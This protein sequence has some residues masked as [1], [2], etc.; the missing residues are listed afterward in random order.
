ME[1]DKMIEFLVAYQ[2]FARGVTIHGTER[3]IHNMYR[4]SA[5][6]GLCAALANFVDI[7]VGGGDG[8]MALYGRMM[9]QLQSAIANL[10][11]DMNPTYPFGGESI[12]AAH[13]R[14]RTQHE[15][16]LRLKFVDDFLSELYNTNIREN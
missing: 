6:T 12:Y 1:D 7:E 3:G 15:N 10:A 8:Y 2:A 14:E 4:F 16:P 13:Y 5:G 11:G 9:Y